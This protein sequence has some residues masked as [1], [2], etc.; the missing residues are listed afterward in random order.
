MQPVGIAAS[1]GYLDTIEAAHRKAVG[2][3]FCYTAVPMTRNGLYQ[4]AIVRANRGGHYTISK[5]YFFGWQEETQR[6]ADELNR[7]RLAL[8]AREAASIVASSMAA[9]TR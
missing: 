4:L 5:D 7:E 2:S 8:M 6:K 9:Q 1:P 3:N